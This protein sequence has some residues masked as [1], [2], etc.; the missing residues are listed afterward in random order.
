MPLPVLVT[1]PS[2]KNIADIFFPMD[3][4]ERI[5]ISTPPSKIPKVHSGSEIYALGGGSVIDYAKMLAGD[6]SC[7]AFPTNASGAVS[8]SHAVIW[9]KTKKIDIK[10]AIPIIPDD[11]DVITSYIDLPII[12][13]RQTYTDCRMHILESRCSKKSNKESIRLCDQAEKLLYKWV[14]G[15]NV[16]YLIC[17]GIYAGKAIEIT[18]TNIFHAISYVFTLDYGY[19]HADALKEALNVRRHKDYKSILK[20]AMKY[21]KFHESTLL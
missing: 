15:G 14:I 2:N 16:Y 7:L 9:T 11:W 18:G 1:S 10:T 5:I 4:Y 19:C 17:A 20:K 12:A 21:P 6:K 3:K 8:T 13:E